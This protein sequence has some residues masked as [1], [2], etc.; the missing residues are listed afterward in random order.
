MAEEM[1]QRRGGHLTHLDV[2]ASRFRC[3]RGHDFFLTTRQVEG[4]EAWCLCCA[5]SEGERRVR[6]CLRE[7]RHLGKVLDFYQEKTFPAE[8]C[9]VQPLWLDFYVPELRLVIEYDGRAHYY[10]RIASGS[11]SLTGAWEVPVS[12]ARRRMFDA[13]SRDQLKDDWCR[14]TGRSMLRIPFW[15]LG[16][17]ETMVGDALRRCAAGERIHIDEAEVWRLE[18]IARLRHGEAASDPPAGG[19]F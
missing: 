9:Y 16:K 19:E 8:L 6:S 4:G 1:A 18:S 17:L 11:S 13:L 14:R 2:D 3:R 10:E 7:A 5:P 12:V 15:R